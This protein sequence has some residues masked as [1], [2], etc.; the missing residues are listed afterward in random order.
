MGTPCV[1]TWYQ[2]RDKN[3]DDDGGVGD[4]GSGGDDDD[5]IAYCVVA[6]LGH[7]TWTS[8]GTKKPFCLS[9]TVEGI[10][11]EP[12]VLLRFVNRRSCR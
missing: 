8:N 3:I 7:I 9:F 12:I 1:N 6:I 2:L 11:L 10:S 4:G 5:D